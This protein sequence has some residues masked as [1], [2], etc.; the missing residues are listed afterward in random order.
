MFSVPFIV[1]RL[2]PHKSA[3]QLQ[4]FVEAC[5]DSVDEYYSETWDVPTVTDLE[6]EEVQVRLVRT[7]FESQFTYNGVVDDI[8]GSFEEWTQ[9][10][11]IFDMLEPEV[12]AF[13]QRYYCFLGWLNFKHIAMSRRSYLLGSRFFLMG[14]VWDV[15]LYTSVQEHFAQFRWLD[16]MRGDADVFSL[17][18]EKN[19]TQL[20]TEGRVTKKI[21]AWVED[22]NAFFHVKPSEKVPAYLENS[23]EVS[24]LD[25]ETKT[26][27][28]RILTV[29]YALKMGDMWRTVTD[30]EGG[31]YE[32]KETKDGLERD[33]YYIQILYEGGPEAIAEWLQ[34]HEDI[35]NW[36][37]ANQ[38]D[39]EFIMKLFRVLY[40]HVDFGNEEVVQN[41][42]Q[43][44]NELKERGLDEID[45]MVFFDE[46][47]GSFKWN[48]E[49][50]VAIEEQPTG[51][52]PAPTSPAAS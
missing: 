32:H 40:Q 24:R 10:L 6:Q 17:A 21:S 29:Y 51:P 37:L 2:Y 8:M 13:L 20:G 23:M 1:A 25:E 33:D 18:I 26:L 31:G 22:F 42:V 27:L 11:V 46:N 34:D 4:P 19:A 5:V 14:A 43:F 16:L 48:D 49:F 30:Q 15:P 36:L 44:A 41:L 45:E 28:D 9:N 52:A 12:N 35:A 47:N 3:E 38:K 7:L 39:E 50:F